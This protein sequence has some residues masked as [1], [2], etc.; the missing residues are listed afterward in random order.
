ME[1][2]FNV[3]Y[4]PTKNSIRYLDAIKVTAESYRDALKDVEDRIMKSI[5]IDEAK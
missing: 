3:W 2:K 4:K 1:Y 5:Q